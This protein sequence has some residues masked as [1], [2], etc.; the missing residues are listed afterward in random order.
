MGNI[1]V[2]DDCYCNICYGVKVI[3]WL[4][5]NVGEG[6]FVCKNKILMSLC[7]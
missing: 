6:I 7:C 4:V 1:F 3:I 2:V 5:G